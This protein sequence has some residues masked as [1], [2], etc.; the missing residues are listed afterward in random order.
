MRRRFATQ[1]AAAVVQV[2]T[3]VN[4]ASA[5]TNFQLALFILWPFGQ[6]TKSHSPQHLPLV[7]LP[8]ETLM[9]LSVAEL[10]L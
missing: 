4:A 10:A 9:A 6:G 7:L 8:A 5:V 1:Q 2:C 3:I